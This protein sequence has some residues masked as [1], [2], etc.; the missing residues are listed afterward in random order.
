MHRTNAPVKRGVGLVRATRCKTT[1]LTAALAESSFSLERSSAVILLAT[2]FLLFCFWAPP[3]FSSVRARVGRGKRGVAVS[4][5]AQHERALYAWC[6]GANCVEILN[7]E[8]LQLGQ[9]HNS[10]LAHLSGCR[11]WRLPL[12]PSHPPAPVPR[13]TMPRSP[14]H[15]S[16]SLR[17]SPLRPLSPARTVVHPVCLASC[18]RPDSWQITSSLPSA[19]SLTRRRNRILSK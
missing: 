15:P 11:C 9:P 18:S 8:C 13:S 7:E 2:F 5:T 3:V 4:P 19:A 14:G 12:S 17:S 1:L 16:V 10:T 6:T